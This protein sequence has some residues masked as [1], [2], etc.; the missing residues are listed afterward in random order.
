M[1]QPLDLGGFLR[2]GVVKQGYNHP[3]KVF[4]PALCA[5]FLAL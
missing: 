5:E 2:A 3:V 1:Q 4:L